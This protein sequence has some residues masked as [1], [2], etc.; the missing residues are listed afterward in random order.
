MPEGVWR[1]KR[2]DSTHLSGPPA[3]FSNGFRF[4]SRPRGLPNDGSLL[5]GRPCGTRTMERPMRRCL[6]HARAP[7]QPGQVQDGI[8][9]DG[10]TA[11][12]PPV[13]T[14]R[15]RAGAQRLSASRLTAH[16][17]GLL[18]LAAG[19]LGSALHASVLDR[20]P[21]GEGEGVRFG[22]RW[23]GASNEGPSHFRAYERVGCAAQKSVPSGSSSSNSR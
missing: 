23:Y 10:T 16:S 11:G 21:T 17:I 15:S 2:D 5:S 3:P 4:R 14:A 13:R 6:S 1:Q 7:A 19:P 12:A 20:T 8:T 18:A 22:A 9:A